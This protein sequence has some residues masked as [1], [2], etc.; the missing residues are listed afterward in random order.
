M[1]RQRGF[2]S[3]ELST[4]TF[5]DL[6]FGNDGELARSKDMGAQ[7][8]QDGTYDVTKQFYLTG[9]GTTVDLQ[10]VLR[11]FLTPKP[12]R[13][14]GSVP[15]PR[16]VV[17]DV[18]C[19]GNHLLVVARD[20]ANGSHNFLYASGLNADG[21]LGL[22]D[23]VSRHELTCVQALSGGIA[24]VAAGKDFSL[25]LSSSALELYSFGRADFGSLGRG[26]FKPP[27]Q[28]P[29]P[30]QV[31]FPGEY[32]VMLKEIAAGDSH[33]LVISL[34][35]KVYTWGYADQLATGHTGGDWEVIWRPRELDLG[36]VKP[37]QAV[38]G[39]QHSAFLVQNYQK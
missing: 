16:K 32:P 30:E 1:S 19:G 20:I 28:R 24:K 15:F 36:D 18:A 29:H 7:P 25:A 38:G 11:E 6:G 3:N 35:D 22:G 5:A 27:F 10:K 23:F 39:S 8:T 12:P 9:D 17:N 14:A 34:E 26:R 31:A 4:H 33:A 21:Q 37:L 13:W 2:V